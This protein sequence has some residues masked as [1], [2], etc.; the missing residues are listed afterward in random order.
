MAA[1]GRVEILKDGAAAIYGSD[2]IGGVVNFITRQ[3]FEGWEAQA[4]YRLV[5]GS[6]G[7][8]GASVAY[9]YVD[10]RSNVFISV[11]YQHRSELSTREREFDDYNNLQNPVAWSVLGNPGT[12]LPRSAANTPVAGVTRDAN[13]DALAGISAFTGTTPACLFDYIPFTNLIEEEN[14]IQIYG[15]L[16]Y[17]FDGGTKFHIEGL[18][19]QTD[20]PTIRF[21]PSY[22]PTQGPNGPGSAGAF[23]AP[24]TNP[25]V[26]A[27]LQQAG[28]SA[29]V[30]AATN[31]VSLTLWRPLG[32]GGNPGTDG[33]GQSGSRHYDIFRVSGGFNGTFDNGIG[34]DIA[35]TYSDSQNRQRTTDVLTFRL[36]QALN[37]F[38]GPACTGNVP[39]A[40]G[41]LW[42]NPFSNGIAGNPALGL[43][44]P[45]FISANANSPELVR[46]L[47]DTQDTNQRQT[48]FVFDLALDGEF[49]W[50]LPGGKIGWAVGGQ[51]RQDIFDSALRGEFQ[52]AAANPC[53]TPGVTTC[54]V[55]TGPYIF[56]GA[57]TP[58]HLETE[59]YAVF[60]ELNIP[61]LDNLNA[62]LAVRYENYG[63]LTGSTTN[64]KFAI[65]WQVFDEFALRG[66]VGTT[67]RGPLAGNRS[68]S[69]IT[70]LSAI[71]AASGGFKSVD[72]IGDP[73]IGPETADTFNV[74]GIFES[75]GLRVTVDYWKYV[76]EDQIVNVPANPV[77]S[78]VAVNGGAG[79]VNCAAPLRF[80]ITFSNNNTCTQGVTV[81]N[82][83]A[84]VR[85]N[86]VNG[87]KI[88]TSGIDVAFDYLLED[89]AGGTLTLGADFSYVL[90]YT[91]EDFIYQGVVVQ[92]GFDAAG[93]TNYD[94][95]VQTISRLRGSAFVDFSYDVHNF[96]FTFTHIGGA[97]DNRAQIF[98]QNGSIASCTVASATCIPVT[99]G[100][101]VKAF[102][103]LDFTYRA[104][105]MENL[106]L[107]ASVFNIFDQEPSAARLE[108]G[109]DPFIGSVYGRSFKISLTSRF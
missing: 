56:L 107:T 58:Q 75:S 48:Q 69:V 10:D 45:G 94:R 31:N 34:W 13:C 60:S 70:A 65:K 92:A 39:G 103:T 93:F 55:K 68:T 38:G 67:F 57:G 61:I 21:S 1:I 9:G 19:A 2:A 96:R 89:V 7:D 88:E 22:P 101:R 100:M 64:P 40:N 105:V 52:N 78:S 54:T 26:L 25:G 76:F 95:A 97:T 84:R 4:D 37:G 20:I 82:D 90:D 72:V 80:L 53:P 99:L 17:E 18:Y 106:T 33:F 74:G 29:G 49:S 43:T 59:V 42:F 63:G 3:N 5:D 28:L 23:I 24:K 98:A 44:N 86:T 46:W 32:N 104:D 27:G 15:E 8:Y 108:Y 102:N 16:N 87:P 51:Y 109:Y 85:A 50:E 12:F 6:D 41:C 35:L 71:T 11:G 36:Q 66:S 83:I 91:Q 77:A 81:G 30:I 79:F 14:R 73:A 47:F 62:Q